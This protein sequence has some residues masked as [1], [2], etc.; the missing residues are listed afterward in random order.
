MGHAAGAG[1]AVGRGREVGE[2][3]QDGEEGD[4]QGGLGAPVVHQPDLLGEREGEQVGEADEKEG[5]GEEGAGGAGGC[6][7]G[8]LGLGICCLVSNRVDRKGLSQGEK[9]EREKCR[10]SLPCPW[11]RR[12]P[13]LGPGR[14]WRWDSYRRS[15]RG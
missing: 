3:G 2:E 12:A 5:D 13:K 15:R 10:R 14:Q 11:L 7:G 8:C 6:E 9:R 4:A 1:A